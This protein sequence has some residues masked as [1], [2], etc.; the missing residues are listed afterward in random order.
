MKKY[1]FLLMAVTSTTALAAQNIQQQGG[2]VG[3]SAVTVNTV[4]VALEVKD[5][6]PVILTGHIVA[7]LGDEEYTFKDDTGEIV[8]EIDSRDW[9]GVE[10]TPDTKLTLQGEVDKEWTQTSIDVNSIK[11]AE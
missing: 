2:F 7:A 5:D 11:L 6:A 9:N 4:K 3:P 8:I 1:I 10:A